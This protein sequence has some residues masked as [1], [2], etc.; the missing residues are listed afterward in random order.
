MKT[1]SSLGIFLGL[2]GTLAGCNPFAPDQSVQLDVTKLDAPA[3]ISSGDA[4][5]VTLTV[6]LNGCERFDHIAVSRDL[7]DA[8]FTVWGIDAS[9]GRKDI[10]CPSIIKSDP[11]SYRLLPPFGN[12]F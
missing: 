7:S 2:V 5:T 1:V 10:A 8:S 12:P 6:T 9:K 3:T 11:H 4:L